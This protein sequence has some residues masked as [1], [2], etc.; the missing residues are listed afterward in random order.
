MFPL[1]FVEISHFLAKAS[2]F[3]RRRQFLLGHLSASA[4]LT[5]KA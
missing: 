2:H 4:S 3:P 1:V 5:M